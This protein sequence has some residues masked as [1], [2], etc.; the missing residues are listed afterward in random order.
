MKRE[1]ITW[2]NRFVQSEKRSVHK[3]GTLWSSAQQQVDRKL[4]DALYEATDAANHMAPTRTF[5]Q[6]GLWEVLQ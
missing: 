6:R 5:I 2:L 1:L 3:L 4:M